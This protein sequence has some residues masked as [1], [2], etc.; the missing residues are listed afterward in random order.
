MSGQTMSRR[1]NVRH[2]AALAMLLGVWLASPRAAHACS[3]LSP[4]DRPLGT[5][6]P[7][8]AVD[9]PLN[10][11][12]E[13]FTSDLYF[14]RLTQDVMP[15][16]R[17]A[18]SDVLLAL[19]PATTRGRVRAVGGLAPDTAYEIVG[20]SLDLSCATSMP[21]VVLATFT[22]GSSMDV[23]APSTPTSTAGGCSLSTCTDSGCCGPYVAGTSS[24]QWTASDDGSLGVVYAFG[25]PDGP[26]LWRTRGTAVRM[27][28][29]HGLYARV[30]TEPLPGA[31]SRAIYAID[32]AGNVSEAGELAA[33]DLSCADGVQL[34]DGGICQDAG[35][36]DA[37]A[38][39][40][41]ASLPQDGDGGARDDPMR[42]APSCGVVRTTITAR[43]IP[44]L[45]T[46]A[47]A[48]LAF[49]RRR[50]R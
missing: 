13:L 9:V 10:V 44:F 48:L 29:G 2:A 11:E 41:D 31:S 26:R 6:P 42:P 17:V 16:L 24:V 3:A 47:G 12:I 49:R 39:T 40:D 19:E 25:A 15:G 33:L 46:L 36:P 34:C 30:T 37:G 35:V 1:H 8:G 21:D 50:A 28:Y 18:G 22:T 14:G 23:V 43:A 45:L 7:D 38:T 27:V 4:C 20:P 5:L 32:A